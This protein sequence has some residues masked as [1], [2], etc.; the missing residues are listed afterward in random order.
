MQPREELSFDVYVVGKETWRPFAKYHYLSDRLPGGKLYLY[1]LFHDS[2]QIGFTCWANYVPTV[3]E[4]VPVFH[5]NR[6]VIHPDYQGLGLGMPLIN[7]SAMHLTAT[8]HLRLM[9]RFSS[10]PLTKAMLRDPLWR[11][12]GDKRPIGRQDGYGP[13]LQRGKGSIRTNV[14]I[15]HFEY[16]GPG[17]VNPSAGNQALQTARPPKKGAKG[18][19]DAALKKLLKR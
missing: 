8:Q 12:L 7:A 4:M 19:S 11:Y 5:G 18:P 16:C 2:V 17:A 15:F 3:R 1:G 14:R 9:G 10:V 13:E 6:T